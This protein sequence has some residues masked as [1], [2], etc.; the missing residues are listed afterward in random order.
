MEDF[1]KVVNETIRLYAKQII[2]NLHSENLEKVR[3]LD[4]SAER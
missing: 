4:M 1:F 2:Q 3:L